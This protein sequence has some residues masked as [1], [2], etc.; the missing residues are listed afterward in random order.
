[1]NLEIDQST[2]YRLMLQIFLEK[3]DF[4]LRHWKAIDEKAI[5]DRLSV[6]VLNLFIVTMATPVDFPKINLSFLQ[7]MINKF[8]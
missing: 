7:P 3:R 8:K 2:G 6:A 5:T 4:I 1:M